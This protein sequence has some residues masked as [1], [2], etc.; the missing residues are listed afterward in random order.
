MINICRK[1][2]KANINDKLSRIFFS[3]VPVLQVITDKIRDD[4]EAGSVENDWKFAAMVIDR[5]CLIGKWDV[6]MTK[7]LCPYKRISQVDPHGSQTEL[8]LIRNSPSRCFWSIFQSNLTN[9]SKHPCLSLHILHHPCHSGCA[10]HSSTCHCGIN[11]NMTNKKWQ[12][13]NFFVPICD[14]PS[15]I[16]HQTVKFHIRFKTQFWLQSKRSYII[17]MQMSD[18]HHH[19]K[20]VNVKLSGHLF[21]L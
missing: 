6:W 10:S 7:V 19:K 4:D 13:Q 12:N 16:V 9:P 11:V 17:K 14:P 20:S 2:S 21:V 18:H 3:R 15:Q 5:L 1:G 8:A